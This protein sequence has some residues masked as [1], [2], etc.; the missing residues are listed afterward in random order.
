MLIL[1]WYF[2]RNVQ[3]AALMISGHFMHEF[4]VLIWWSGSRPLVLASSTTSD[5]YVKGRRSSRII[6]GRK[7]KAHDQI[8]E[9]REKGVLAMRIDPAVNF[10]QWKAWA[11]D[12]EALT[13]MIR[14]PERAVDDPSTV[15]L[16]YVYTS[17]E[18]YYTMGSWATPAAD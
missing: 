16:A 10:L 7:E 18:Q 8:R 2:R 11:D 9:L 4:V 5:Q 1:F 17:I 12:D 13:L 3:P 15:N 6:K 14:S